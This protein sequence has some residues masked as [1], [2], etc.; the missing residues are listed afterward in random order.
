VGLHEERKFNSNETA[1]KQ[2]MPFLLRSFFYF[3]T[4]FTLWRRK[5]CVEKQHKW[6]QHSYWLQ[7][8]HAPQME[9][10][11]TQ[12]VF[13]MNSDSKRRA[14]PLLH[15]TPS[16]QKVCR[17]GENRHKTKMTLELHAHTEASSKMTPCSLADSYLLKT[18][19]HIIENANLDTAVNVS[20]SSKPIQ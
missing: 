8:S 12:A 14:I 7:S 15:Q 5:F 18:R 4:L 2:A 1:L 13:C 10:Q 16:N 17:S 20:V 6:K 19:R 3:V 11:Y 9:L